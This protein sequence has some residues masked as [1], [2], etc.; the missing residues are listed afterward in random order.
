MLLCTIN[1]NLISCLDNW[2]LLYAQKLAIKNKVS[3][4]ITFCRL[5]KFLDCSLRHYKHIF[6]GKTIRIFLCIH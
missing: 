6:E 5:T 3:L 4:H 2:A 1:F